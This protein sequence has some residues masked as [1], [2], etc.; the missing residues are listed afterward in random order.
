MKSKIL[1]ITC[2]ILNVLFACSNQTASALNNINWNS[3]AEGVKKAADSDKKVFIY[4]RAD[5]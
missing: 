2:V 5:W 1:I 3:L 4:F